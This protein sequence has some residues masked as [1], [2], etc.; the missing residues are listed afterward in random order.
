[1]SIILNLTLSVKR[2]INGKCFCKVSVGLNERWR[3]SNNLN[4]D[5]LAR[6]AQYNDVTIYDVINLC[7]FFH[8]WADD[9][10]VLIP[11]ENFI[12]TGPQT[13]KIMGGRTGLHAPPEPKH[14]KK[15]QTD[16]RVKPGMHGYLLRQDIKNI[17]NHVKLKT[18][19]S[20]WPCYAEWRLGHA[21]KGLL[22]CSTE[23]APWKHQIIIF[24]DLV[25]LQNRLPAS[26]ICIL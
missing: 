19:R 12:A 26:T 1:M 7:N 24:V 17:H 21:L 10:I 4:I 11:I 2:N 25:Q 18:R 16:L 15:A 9:L 14:V 23:K 5:S 20:L 8:I 22:E 3:S 13:M 6:C